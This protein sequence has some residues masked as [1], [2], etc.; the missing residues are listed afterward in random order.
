MKPLAIIAVG[1]AFTAVSC[2]VDPQIIKELPTGNLVEVIP[3]GWPQPVYTFTGNAI[4][5]DKFILGR[6]LFYEPM[7]SVNNEISCGFCHTQANAFSDKEHDLSHGINDLKGVRNAPGIFNASWHPYFMHDGGIINLELQPVGPITN[8]IEMGETMAGV[9]SKLQASVKYRNLFLNAYG[10]EEVT[11][12]RMLKALAQ[13]MG[14]MYSYNSKYDQVKRGEENVS[15][16]DSEKRG[17]E[18]FQQHCNSCHAEPLFTDFKFRSNGMPV[19][20]LKDS[21][22]AHIEPLPE[23]RYKFK[24]PSLRNVEVTL[25]YMHDGSYTTLQKCIDHYTQAKPNPINLDPLLQQPMQLS[26]Q[27]ELDLI[28]FLKTLTDHT[29][30]NDRRFSDPNQP[31]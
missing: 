6:A 17:Y 31:N 4:T 28:A 23:N 1:L 14:L 8:P 29:F 30:L 27:D 19:T 12:Q 13:F 2:K 7:L 11:T 26:T 5:Q 3:Q 10:S 25:P 22:R 18:L 15:F 24:T 20:A 9:V 16:D 21:G